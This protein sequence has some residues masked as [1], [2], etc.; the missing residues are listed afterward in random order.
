[1]S[2]DYSIERW[3]DHVPRRQWLAEESRWCEIDETL[4]LA[5]ANNRELAEVHRLD[6]SLFVIFEE[7]ALR[8]SGALTRSAP[9]IDTL[10]FCAQQ[11]LDEARHLEM[12]QRRLSLSAAAQGKPAAP[13]LAIMS[14]PLKRF[15]ERCYEVVDRGAFVEGLTLMNLI[16]EGMAF[17]LYAYEE[18]YW[19]PV[20]PFL[21]SLVRSAYADES[22]H[23]GFGAALVKAALQDDPAKR[24]AVKTL[25]RDAT[26]A[27]TEV[28][29]YYVRTFVS[30]FDA[31]A[32]RHGELFEGAEFAPGKTIAATPYAEQ[33]RTIQ[34]TMQQ[35]HQKLLARAGLV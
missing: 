18:R 14:P 13:A 25:C 3:V 5:I 9:D 7:A 29:D 11:T 21:G 33:V 2:I 10:N 35:E 6:L 22:R 27:M 15:L 4:P 17:P 20:D 12:F 32:K 23:V 26:E 19:Q 8:V 30:L 24:A 16:F 31:V 1:M 34:Q 28:F